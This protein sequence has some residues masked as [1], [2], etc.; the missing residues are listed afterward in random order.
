M[1]LNDGSA[2]SVNISFFISSLYIRATVLELHMMILDTGS[3]NRSD[4]DFSI[5]GRVTQK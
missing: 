3:H 4:S 1:T 2:M 5:S